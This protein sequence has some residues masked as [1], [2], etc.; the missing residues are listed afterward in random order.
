MS[1]VDTRATKADKSKYVCIMLMKD[2]DFRLGVSNY[3]LMVCM[4]FN[5]IH[6]PQRIVS[7]TLLLTKFNLFKYLFQYVAVDLNS[8]GHVMVKKG[9][10]ITSQF[11]LQ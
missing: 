4:M 9:L 8:V 10:F 2:T 6:Y 1:Q 7:S 11:N 5:G 3:K